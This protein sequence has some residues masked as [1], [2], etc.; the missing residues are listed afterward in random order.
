[1]RIPARR[2]SALPAEAMSAGRP[3]KRSLAS[4]RLVEAELLKFETYQKEVENI[5]GVITGEK[6]T[7]WI[8]TVRVEAIQHS[9]FQLEIF[10]LKYCYSL[11]KQTKEHKL[12]TEL[13]DCT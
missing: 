5:E 13:C 11:A 6:R 12:G 3:G 8:C 9:A 7:R 4:T 10:C 1:M 2:T